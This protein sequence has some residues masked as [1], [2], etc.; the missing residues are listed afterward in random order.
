MINWVFLCMFSGCEPTCSAVCFDQPRNFFRSPS[1]SSPPPTPELKKASKP[2]HFVTRS[3]PGLGQQRT[4]SSQLQTQFCFVF[5]F[6]FLSSRKSCRPSGGASHE[7][8]S[9]LFYWWMYFQRNL[10]PEVHCQLLWYVFIKFFCVQSFTYVM[11][12]TSLTPYPQCLL[13]VWKQGF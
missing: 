11:V 13:V 9:S 4:P 1:F 2:T 3:S 5:F 8:Y 7:G 10:C 12:N 6:P